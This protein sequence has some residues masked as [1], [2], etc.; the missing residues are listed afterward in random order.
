MERILTKFSLMEREQI[1]TMFV[2]WIGESIGCVMDSYD[3]LEW[4]EDCSFSDYFVELQEIFSDNDERL[5][6]GL[7]FISFKVIV[8]EDTLPVLEEIFDA[9]R[10]DAYESKMKDFASSLYD[11]VK[12]YSPYPEEDPCAY[13]FEEWCEKGEMN[14]V[15][16]D[17]TGRR[18]YKIWENCLKRDC[19]NV[20]IEDNKVYR[21]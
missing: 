21:Y 8:N 15:F 19:I 17:E 9:A 1:A 14:S 5:G 6:E 3:D 16:V 20:Y 18:I 11:E 12:D 10:S 7:D 2:D 13:D 4:Y